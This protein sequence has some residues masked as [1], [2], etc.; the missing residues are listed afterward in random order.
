MS[1]SRGLF[2]GRSPRSGLTESS[3]VLPAP[4]VDRD[5]D[6][7]IDSVGT[8]GRGLSHTLWELVSPLRP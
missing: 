8:T 1:D 7:F 5:L 6:D 4:E 2:F 3:G